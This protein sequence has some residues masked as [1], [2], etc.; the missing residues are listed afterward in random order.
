MDAQPVP[1][2]DF[3]SESTRTHA[4]GLQADRRVA[5]EISARRNQ[6][7]A[8]IMLSKK[9]IP[10]VEDRQLE[11]YIANQQLLREPTSVKTIKSPH[12]EPKPQSGH[13]AISTRMGKQRPKFLTKSDSLVTCSLEELGSEVYLKPSSRR[14]RDRQNNVQTGPGSIFLTDLQLEDELRTASQLTDCRKPTPNDQK[15]CPG[16]QPLSSSA[17]SEY[18]GVVELPVSG[19]GHVA[20]GKYKLWRPRQAIFN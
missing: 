3:L 8:D 4:G 14:I 11:W 7:K 12:T 10:L 16:W 13:V 19:I 9:E 17:L 2:T 18:S 20:H 1:L 6:R 5:M 15:R